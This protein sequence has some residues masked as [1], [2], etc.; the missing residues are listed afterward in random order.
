MSSTVV[1]RL[2]ALSLIWGGG[3]LCLGYMLHPPSTVA[4]LSDPIQTPVHLLIFFGTFLVLFG[5]MGLYARQSRRMGILGL[6]G[7]GL[8]MIEMPHTVGVLG[9]FPILH[10]KAPGQEFS[11]IQAF[12]ST[13][14]IRNTFIDSDSS[15]APGPHRNH[16]ITS[17]RRVALD[18]DSLPHYCR[19]QFRASSP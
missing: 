19:P 18:R 8:P 13:P 15:N 16:D 14:G 9:L 17:T 11:W 2:S 5:L 12:F 6:L 10:T 7:F 1:Y 3:F 4:A